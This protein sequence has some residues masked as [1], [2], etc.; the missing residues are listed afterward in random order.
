MTTSLLKLCTIQRQRLE[1]AGLAII[2]EDLDRP[3]GGF[4]II[5]ESQSLEFAAHFLPEFT[6]R[7]KANVKLSPKILMVGPDK[8]LSW[9]YHL[10]RA[11]IWKCLQGPVQVSSS[12]TNTEANRQILNTGQLISL[13]Q[14]ERHR[15]IGLK[16]W[17]VIAEI[18]EH[19]VDG[20][21]SDEHDIVRL[22]DDFGR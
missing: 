16:N 1:D 8:R 11:E 20:Y 10:R 14:G 2:A 21:P 4:F 12:F 17:A 15:L 9:Q 18:W 19:T 5:D 13:Q 7:A 6:E 3:W 22:Q